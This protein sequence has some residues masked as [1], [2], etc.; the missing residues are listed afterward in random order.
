VKRLPRFYTPPPQSE[1]EAIVKFEVII[2]GAEEKLPGLLDAYESVTNLNFLCAK[3]YGAVS[4]NFKQIF[5]LE[6]YAGSAYA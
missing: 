4:M 5:H 1:L 2:D 3:R 6:F